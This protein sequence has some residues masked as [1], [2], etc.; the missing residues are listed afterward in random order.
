MEISL[1]A[2]IG[3]TVM[4]LL[5][6]LYFLESVT[7]RSVI[8]ILIYTI[9]LGYLITMVLIGTLSATFA[10]CVED[11]CLSVEITKVPTFFDPAWIGAFKILL[12]LIISLN[13]IGN[14]ETTRFL[15]REFGLKGFI[16][17]IETEKRERA[18]HRTHHHA[19]RAH[20]NHQQV[21][22]GNKTT[23][24]HRV[25]H[26]D[27]T[28]KNLHHF[29]LSEKLKME[30]E[31]LEQGKITENVGEENKSK[32]ETSDGLIEISGSDFSDSE[33]N[34]LKNENIKNENTQTKTAISPEVEHKNTNTLSDNSQ[35]SFSTIE[36]LS[37]TSTTIIPKSYTSNGISSV[38]ISPSYSTE[39]ENVEEISSS[40]IRK[41]DI[42]PLL[43]IRH[44]FKAIC[45]V[46]TIFATI[47][48]FM[49]LSIG[50][51]ICE[52][53]YRQASTKFCSRAHIVTL[54]TLFYVF[55][56]IQ[57][58]ITALNTNENL[59]LR[60]CLLLS[61]VSV[62]VLNILLVVSPY[63]NTS[64]E[65]IITVGFDLFAQMFFAFIIFIDLKGVKCE[66]HKLEES[67]EWERMK[68]TAD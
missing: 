17:E 19:I 3:I 32:S 55:R 61:T 38:T 56:S 68:L 30:V 20:K 25:F 33:E 45:R 64:P 49:F 1:F 58:Y 44:I 63:Y 21:K 7:R 67:I 23:K 50:H 13:V 4:A 18:V 34:L 29:D 8:M 14:I 37:G 46:V 15:Y 12:Y 60:I 5:S 47:L 10:K 54:K 57:I 53:T 59:K 28:H 43:A 2:D 35:P 42:F 39:D 16:S 40:E 27:H 65:L 62:I 52:A 36:T 6:F 41:V 51:S 66:L 9:L 11:P 48:F 31:G 26:L 24:T 22:K